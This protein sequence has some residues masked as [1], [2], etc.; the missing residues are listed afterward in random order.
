MAG[1]GYVGY[2]VL[3]SRTF[4]PFNYGSHV[5]F[6]SAV[7]YGDYVFVPAAEDYTSPGNLLV[8][9]RGTRDI[10][11]TKTLSVSPSSI[12]L[13]PA[14]VSIAEI[15]ASTDLIG[16]RGSPPLFYISA[17]SRTYRTTSSYVRPMCRASA[18]RSESSVIPGMVFTSRA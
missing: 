3:S 11:D 17:D 16:G 15:S 14:S 5:G 6:S 13:I 4:L 12:T 2:F 1:Y 18:G 10:V 7:V 8:F 9:D